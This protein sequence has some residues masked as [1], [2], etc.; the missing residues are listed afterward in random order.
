MQMKKTK[1]A[2]SFEELIPDAELREK[3]KAHLYSKKAPFGEGSIFSKV[4]HSA[5]NGLFN[6]EMEDFLPEE[7]VKENVNKSNGYTKKIINSLAGP[8]EIQTPRDRASDFEPELIGKRDRELSSGMD[9]QIL[10]LYDQGDSIEDVRRPL[11][12]ILTYTLK[13][14]SKG[15]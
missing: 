13:M 6:G 10:A 3:A 12:K 15:E 14:A 9:G 8:L 4:L 2:P 5:V 7:L 11:E 1:K